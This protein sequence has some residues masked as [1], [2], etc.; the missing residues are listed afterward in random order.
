MHG[1]LFDGN[2]NFYD[3]YHHFHA[4]QFR[5]MHDPDVDFVTGKGQM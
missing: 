1:L 2:G 3:I 4:I 5:N